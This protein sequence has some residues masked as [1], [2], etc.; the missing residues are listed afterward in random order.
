MTNII[1]ST[2]GIFSDP[3]DTKRVIEELQKSSYDMKKLSLFG[4]L[5]VSWITDP[6]S[7]S[8][9]LASIGIPRVS[10]QQYENALRTNKFIL[11]VQG[12]LQEVGSAMYIFIQ[13]RALCAECHIGAIDRH[14]EA[15]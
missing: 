8:A 11:I 3:Q 4:G 12:N 6:L 9:V 14:S 5:V 15:A 2:V 10:I 7:L 1:N 13:N